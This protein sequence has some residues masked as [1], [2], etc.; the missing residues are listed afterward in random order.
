MYEMMFP[1]ANPELAANIL[2]KLGLPRSVRTRD[3]WIEPGPDGDPILRILT[4]VGGGNRRDYNEQIAKLQ[5]H[6][7]YLFDHDETEWDS[8]YASF[9]FRVPDFLPAFTAD[10]ITEEKPVNMS[11]RSAAALKAASERWERGEF[12]EA[13][14][15]IRDQLSGLID[16]TT[17][18]GIIEI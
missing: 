6:P 14:Q 18:R 10:M 16:G 12:T 2:A 13:E 4:R 5:A 9:Y 17:T 11:E 15:R 1:G 3:A 8:T 7:Q